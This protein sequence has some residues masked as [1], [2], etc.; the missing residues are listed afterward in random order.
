[1]LSQ[2]V[3]A[4]QI[5]A[6]TF[7]RAAA[8][9]LKKRVRKMII[10]DGHKNFGFNQK[11]Q[12]Y[13]A[14]GTF[15]SICFSILNIHCQH[16]GFTSGKLSICGDKKIEGIVKEALGTLENKREGGTALSAERQES[17]KGA[18]EEK[19]A[20]ATKNDVDTYVNFIR[21]AKSDGKEP[22]EYIGDYAFVYQFYQDRLK[23]TNSI[24]FTDMIRLTVKLFKD[25]PKILELYRD[26]HRFILVDEFQVIRLLLLFPL[27]SDL[28]DK[29][30]YT[31][32]YEPDTIRAFVAVD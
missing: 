1:M 19:Q 18:N 12:F 14:T 4:H 26:K 30:L 10:E 13:L 6:L 3:P 11:E 16:L 21:R 8:E 2:G 15:H 9:E 25:H 31:A 24:D 7:T 28:A 22:N 29:A 20:D 17:Q 23:E 32:G 5:I 27:P